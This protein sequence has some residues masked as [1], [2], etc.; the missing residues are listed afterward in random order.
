LNLGAASADKAP[1]VIG[2]PIRRLREAL[3]FDPIVLM[4][5]NSFSGQ[6]AIVSHE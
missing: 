4:F 5:R 6:K 2:A 1:A 3:G